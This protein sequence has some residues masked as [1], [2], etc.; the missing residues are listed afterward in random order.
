VS[1]TYIVLLDADSLEITRSITNALGVFL[2]PAF[3]PGAYRLRTER[4]GYRSTVSSTL[5][6]VEYEAEVELEVG[7]SAY[8]D[9]FIPS[10][11]TVVGGPCTVVLEAH[12]R[13]VYSLA[14][15]E[16][17]GE[18]VRWLDTRTDQVG[19]FRA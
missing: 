2:I 19:M 7:T 1:G 12:V 15:G 8:A 6:G 17:E 14:G 10:A 4:I 18:V 5:L 9:L 3:R 11:V 16:H 13:I